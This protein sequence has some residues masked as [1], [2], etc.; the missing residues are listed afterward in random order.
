[1]TD[2]KPYIQPTVD[3]VDFSR[4]FD[5][6]NV[7]R[8]LRELPHLLCS[9]ELLRGMIADNEKRGVSV[10]ERLRCYAEFL[11]N[12]LENYKS[13]I[14]KLGDIDR[15]IAFAVFISGKTYAEIADSL[16]Y[17]EIGVRKKV[18][19]IYECICSLLTMYDI[20]KAKS[21]NENSL[22]FNRF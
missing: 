14:D 3:V 22:P 21:G 6:K 16:G 12:R 18:N 20:Q 5:I 17:S 1:M 4:N 15:S 19:R 9:L 8:E 13:A 2:K 10:P 7:R 11:S